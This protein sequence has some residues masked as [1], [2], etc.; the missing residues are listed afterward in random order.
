[1]AGA[2]WRKLHAALVGLGIYFFSQVLPYQ[3]SVSF[4]RSRQ[5]ANP[6]RNTTCITMLHSKLVPL[7]SYRSREPSDVEP[8]VD[9]L[10]GTEGTRKNQL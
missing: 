9:W 7:Q 1:M 8:R 3:S 4:G 5:I 10:A 6:S 2:D